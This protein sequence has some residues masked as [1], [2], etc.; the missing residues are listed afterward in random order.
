MRWR[1]RSNQPYRNTLKLSYVERQH[2]RRVVTRALIFSGR[3]VDVAGPG[4]RFKGVADTD[5]V[6]AQ[7]AFS[8]EAKITVVPPAV[9]LRVLFKQSEAV[10]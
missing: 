10:V 7:A 6:D 5:M 4:Q 1:R 8:P 2:H 9:A 3:G